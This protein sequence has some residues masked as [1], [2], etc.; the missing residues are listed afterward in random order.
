MTFSHDKIGHKFYL[1]K[2][3][4][5]KP[6]SQKPTYF[7]QNLQPVL[8]AGLVSNNVKPGFHVV[9]PQLQHQIHKIV[10]RSEVLFLQGKK[11]NQG[12]TNP[13][14]TA[15]NPMLFDVVVCWLIPNVKA[16]TPPSNP[17]L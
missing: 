6:M 17:D 10:D 5:G 7:V 11:G 12:K 13:H 15:Q 2:T 3:D 16:S 4:S 9:V 1:P 14:S 8:K